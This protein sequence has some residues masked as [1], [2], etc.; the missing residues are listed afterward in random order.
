MLPRRQIINI[1]VD[2]YNICD[3]CQRLAYYM[4]EL[5]F[6]LQPVIL[7]IIDA[8]ENLTA[9]TIC[10]VVFETNFCPLFDDEYNWTVNIDDNPGRTITEKE[11]NE[12]IN[13]VQITDIHY[14]PKYEPDGNANCGEP[15]CCRKGQNNTNTSDKLAGFWGDYN[16]CDTPWHA[17]IDALSHIKDTHNVGD[18]L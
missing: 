5:R 14:D 3:I 9:S 15:A 11:N 7:Y 6:Y 12:T 2:I 17:V 10:G 8:R 16:N 13:I 18:L 4:S 1:V